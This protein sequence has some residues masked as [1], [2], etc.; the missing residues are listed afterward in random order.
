MMLDFTIIICLIIL[1]VI[2]LLF[3]YNSNKMECFAPFIK[4]D[5]FPKDDIIKAL[6]DK[7]DTYTTTN[8]NNFIKSNIF[9]C[10]IIGN[11]E[12]FPPGTTMNDALEI[13]SK[14]NLGGNGQCIGILPFNKKPNPNASDMD[15]Y[16]WIG[17]LSIAY[18]SDCPCRE[19]ISTWLNIEKRNVNS[20]RWG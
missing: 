12:T 13:C 7:I 11:P 14:A 5:A 1:L 8:G 19:N 20:Y 10:D 3:L 9:T 6:D 15:V 2:I 4:P 18:T 17:C 16:P